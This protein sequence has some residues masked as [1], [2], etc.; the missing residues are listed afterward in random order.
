AADGSSQ[1]PPPELAA[2]LR[3]DP[4]ADGADQSRLLG[5]GDQLAGRHELRGAVRCRAA[6]AQERLEAGQRAAWKLDDR[7]VQQA[8]LV[9]LQ[10]A[11]QPRLELEP[12]PRHAAHA[13]CEALDLIAA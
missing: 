7:L 11:A 8:E 6:P 1:P 2:R 4:T 3:D 5:H 10:R 9:S 13:G 12:R